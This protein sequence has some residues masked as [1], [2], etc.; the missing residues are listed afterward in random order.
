MI[1]TIKAENNLFINSIKSLRVER[2]AEAV[3]SAKLRWFT[4]TEKSGVHTIHHNSQI[5]SL[6]IKTENF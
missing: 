2:R 4:V 6:K 5:K 3:I 1:S